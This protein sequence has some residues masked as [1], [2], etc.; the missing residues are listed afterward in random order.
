M[1]YASP[2]HLIVLTGRAVLLHGDLRVSF[3]PVLPALEE[4]QLPFA[5]YSLQPQTESVDSRE[6]GYHLVFEYGNLLEHRRFV[7]TTEGV[8]EYDGLEF[9]PVDRPHIGDL[10]DEVINLFQ[11]FL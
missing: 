2:A 9:V 1:R 4:L 6:H 3:P 10:G 5:R 11:C 8:D 7:I